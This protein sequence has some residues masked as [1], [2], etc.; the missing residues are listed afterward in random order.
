MAPKKEY[1]V[2]ALDGINY[3][4]NPVAKCHFA[5]DGEK[6]IALTGR[7][8]RHMLTEHMELVLRT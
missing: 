4:Y 2:F 1:Y 3:G 6:T 7:E 8:Y 5:T